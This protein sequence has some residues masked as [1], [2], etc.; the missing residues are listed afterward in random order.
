MKMT[1]EERLDWLINGEKQLG[2]LYRNGKMAT[3]R[4]E[5]RGLKDTA[6]DYY[7]WLRMWG[8]LLSTFSKDLIPA[9]NG[10]LHYRWMISYF[11]CHSFMDKNTL[12]LRGKPLERLRFARER[13]TPP[14]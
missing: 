2:K 6:Y 10:A 1:N 7:E 8:M 13:R 3:V 11:C 14:P 4:R 5:W 9:L 12:G